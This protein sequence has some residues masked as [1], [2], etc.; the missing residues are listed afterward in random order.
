MDRLPDAVGAL[1]P[2]LEAQPANTTAAYTRSMAYIGL[3][4]LDK[5]EHLINK[6]FRQQNT[7]EA[8]LVLGSFHLANGEVSKAIEEL[9]LA[10]QSNPRLPTVH[11]QLGNAYLSTGAREQAAKEFTAEL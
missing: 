2:V 5:A 9:K 8:H 6:A 3:R 10:S 4:Q 11:S 7:V 1:D